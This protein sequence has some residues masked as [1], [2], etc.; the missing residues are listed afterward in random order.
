MTE[1]RWADALSLDELWQGDIIDVELQGEQILLVHHES[2][3]ILAFQGMCPHQEVLLADGT[4]DEDSGILECPGHNWQFDLRT[5]DG[6]NPTG[7]RLYRYVVRVVEERIQ[8]GIP[9]DGV[10]HHNRAQEAEERHDA[11]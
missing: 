5:G 6:V 9:D 2:G 1:V 7:C 8:V 3:D 4:W 11:S 10:R